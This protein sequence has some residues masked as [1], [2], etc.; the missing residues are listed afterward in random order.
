MALEIFEII[1]W[2]LVTLIVF[3]FW[4]VFIS[5]ALTIMQFFLQ[6]S[7]HK[8]LFSTVSVAL[9]VVLV[10]IGYNRHRIKRLSLVDMLPP[11][12]YERKKQEWTQEAMEKLMKNP[13]FHEMK[14]KLEHQDTNTRMD[15]LSAEDDNDWE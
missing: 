2:L 12:E 15:I 14:S 11:D 1:P 13:K 8:L 10:W 5:A 6:G 3:Y 7:L 4:D 9:A